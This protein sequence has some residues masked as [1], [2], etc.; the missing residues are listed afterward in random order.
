[1]LLD[2]VSFSYRERSTFRGEGLSA[3]DRVSL[4][5]RPGEKVGVVGANGAGKSTLLRLMA[6]IL[7][8][9]SGSC[10]ARHMS[11]ALL[12]LNAGFDPDL[13]GAYNVVMHGMLSGL[14]RREAVRRIPMVAE[15]GGLGEA[16]NRRVATFST[17]MRARLCFWTAMNLD[18]DVLLVDE[19]LSVGDL[20]FRERSREAMLDMIAGNRAVVIASHNLNFVQSV[21]D[22]TIWLHGG[23]V[24]ADGESAAVIDSYRASLTPPSE[25]TLSSGG[26]TPRQ[27]FVCGPPRSGTTALARLLN[28]NPSLV[29]GIERY[30][31]RLMQLRGADDST[32]FE[33]DRYFTYDPG[34]T[35]VDFNVAHSELTRISKRKFDTAAYVGDKVPRLYRRL[36]YIDTAF[37]NCIVIYIIRDPINVAASWQR[38]AEAE[39][40]RWPERNGYQQAIIEW[41]ESVRLAMEARRRFGGR[42]ILL[43][44]ERIFGNRRLA[45]WREMMRRLQLSAKTDQSTRQFLDNAFRRAKADRG[46]EPEILRYAS[47]TADYIAYARLLAHV[48]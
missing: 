20:A 1:M 35:D 12:S 22:R 14:S 24:F 26:A 45:V 32:L 4:G 34:D 13:S 25:A 48:L 29:V 39:Q 3:L 30:R 17:G 27:L 19:V 41:N 28:T 16:I 44:Y 33:R 2:N 47:R 5:I 43:S 31:K 18:A 8:P 10:D 36:P 37:P 46:I 7:Q 9:S 6:G 38:R 11:R 15:M 21:C 42:M 23:R 40:D